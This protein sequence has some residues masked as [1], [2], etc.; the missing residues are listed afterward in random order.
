M[1]E[2][3]KEKGFVIKDRRFFDETGEGC[4]K[5]WEEAVKPETTEAH[6]APG[7]Q[8]APSV[9][10]GTGKTAGNLSAGGQLCQF[11]PFA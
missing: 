6:S 8:E 4:R 9:E 7:Q 10:P 3:K 1:E 5:D 2:E 11:H